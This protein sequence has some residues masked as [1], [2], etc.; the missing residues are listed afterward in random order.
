MVSTPWTTDEIELLVLHINT[1]STAELYQRYTQV[2]GTRRSYDS[3]QKQCRRLRE[4]RNSDTELVDQVSTPQLIQPVILLEN[5]ILPL[6]GA[7]NPRDRTLDKKNYEKD[8]GEFVQALSDYSSDKVFTEVSSNI[9]TGSSLCIVLSDTHFGKHTK[10]FNMEEARKRILSITDKIPELNI[11]DLEEVVIM[12]AGDMIEGE[13]IYHTQA[14]HIEDSAIQ[15]IKH[16]VSA[17][18]QLAID[19]RNAHDVT[20]R[21]ETCPGNHGRVSR[22]A[23]EE[24]NWDNIIYQMLGLVAQA[25][26]DSKIVVNVN[27]QT[28]RT[29]DVQGKTGLIY[30]HGTK[31]TG[32]PA[33]QV[34]LVG[35]MQTKNWDFLAHGHWHQYE[36][37]TQ[38]GKPVFKNGSLPGEDDL[39][40]RMG[41]FDPPRQAWFLVRKDQPISTFGF[42]QWEQG[43]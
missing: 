10:H 38:F 33:M 21:F 3:V 2:F 14:H 18:W 27:F 22:T 29:F 15:Q 26:N 16:A 6:P 40:E 39:A 25:Y 9:H 19:I 43:H 4:L 36:V 12:L 8:I 1:L 30:H 41:V 7:V 5:E 24:T 23:S 31:H 34:K 35:W 13:D 42:F 17:F 11:P 32:T 37:G 28:F 20:V